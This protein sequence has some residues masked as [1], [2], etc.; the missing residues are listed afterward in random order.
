[1]PESLTLNVCG[2]QVFMVHNKKLIPK[3]LA[4]IRLVVYGHSH[5]YEEKESGGIRYLNPGSCGPRRFRQEITLAILYIE[6]EG[7]FRIE[8]I[9]INPPEKGNTRNT[10]ENISDEKITTNIAAMLPA[11]MREIDAG[12][13]VEQIA[14][15]HHISEEL[16]DQINRM[17][18]TH[19][20]VDA[21]GI[22]SRL[23]LF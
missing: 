10:P 19:P 11:I 9:L 1:M 12:K 23:G 7:I 22:L 4:E 3:D 16:S 15:K 2:I 6:D 21:D 17:Y 20:G 8:K 14:A 18:L 13:T 5:R